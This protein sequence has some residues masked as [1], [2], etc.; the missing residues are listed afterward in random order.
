MTKMFYDRA[1][2]DTH[3]LDRSNTG[4]MGLNPTQG[5]DVCRVVL[6]RR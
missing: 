5:T 1:L 3:G 6:L 4:F 2:Y